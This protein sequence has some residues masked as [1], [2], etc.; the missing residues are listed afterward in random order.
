MFVRGNTLQDVKSYFFDR[1]AEKFSKS[2]LNLMI[3]LIVCKRLKIN[4]SDYIVS[5]GLLFSES[6]LLHIRDYVIRLKNDEPFQYIFGEVEFYG[7]H[8]KIDKRGLIPR[9]ETEELVDWLVNSF[10]Q[11]EGGKIL[12]MCSGS[13]CI[14]LG[15]KSK[16]T[17]V[18]ITAAEYS[19]DALDLMEENSAFTK[20]NVECL[21]MNALNSDDYRLFETASYDVWVSNPPYI[22]EEDKTRMEANVLNFEPHIAL[23]VEDADPLI[24][25]RRIATE[26]RRV[27]KNEGFLFFEI[28][29]DFGNEL[30]LLLETLGF[31][32]I[33]LRKDLQGKERMMRA[34]NVNS[35]HES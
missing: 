14:A 10:S 29:E 7:I 17:N 26:A 35:R 24:F 4:E 21:S 34:Q 13:G 20:L 33:E 32:N 19:Q 18:E 1:L 28:H 25:Y 30:R 27:L 15:I 22:P 9:P 16:L 12:D 3:K 2:E 5:Q 6:D 23:F 11:H 8:L 31:V